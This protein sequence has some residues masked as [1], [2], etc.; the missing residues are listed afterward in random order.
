MFENIIFLYNTNVLKY[1]TAIVK[2]NGFVMIHSTWFIH[3]M[4]GA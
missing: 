3:V 4:M 1:C 2:I